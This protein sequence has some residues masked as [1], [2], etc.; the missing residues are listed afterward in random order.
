VEGGVVDDARGVLCDPAEAILAFGV[1]IGPELAYLVELGFEGESAV[2][3][4]VL[5]PLV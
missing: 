4:L 5:K 1:H 3:V 2:L